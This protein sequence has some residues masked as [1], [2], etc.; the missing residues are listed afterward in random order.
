MDRIAVIGAGAWGTALATVA[1]RAGR[2]VVLW[3]LEP[4]VAEAVN[5]RHENELFLRGIPLDP[6]IRATTQ[7]EDACNAAD[8]VLLVPPA[9]HL[10]AVTR[11]LLPVLPAGTGVVICSKGIEQGS[12]ALMA[13]VFA[14]EAPTVGCATLSGPTLANEVARGLPTAVTL[15]SRSPDLAEA[16]ARALSSRSLKVYVSDEVPGAELGG[17]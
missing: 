3:A 4:E 8:L 17:R 6:G 11:A 13:E 2:E 12:C 7:V 14:E 9:Q 15:A 16:T 10:R 1:H 5:A